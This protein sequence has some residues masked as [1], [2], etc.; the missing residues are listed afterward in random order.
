MK[1]L[2]IANRAEIAV[3]IAR[4]ARSM[5]IETVAVV[6]EADR[7]ALITEMVDA[8]ALIGPAPAAQSYLA[9]D[10]ILAA[11]KEFGADA[12]HP[13]YGFLSEN[14]GSRAV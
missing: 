7:D 8:V 13:G 14:A 9:Q 6:S 4:T 10:A 12:V 1:R 5:G 3:R 2:L 11:A